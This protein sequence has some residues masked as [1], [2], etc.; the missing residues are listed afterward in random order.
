MGAPTR[1]TNGVT[2]VSKAAPM[3]A[4]PLP[5]PIHSS[6]SAG[7]QVFS[8]INDFTEMGTTTANTLVNST[9]AGVSEVGGVAL[10]T[11]ATAAVASVVRTAANF[12]FVT[13]SDF[14]YVTRHKQSAITA[15][16]TQRVGLQN[17]LLA[18]TTQESIYFTSTAGGALSLVSNVAGVA[19]TLVASVLPSIAAATYVDVG[20]YFDGNDLSVFAND[21]LVAKVTSPSL[22]TLILSPF[23]QITPTAALE[24]LSQDYVIVAQETVR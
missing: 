18:N 6:V 12:Q 1:F 15:A 17:G 19:T 16:V 9:Y 7:K 11:P 8:Y 4:Y 10:L 23:A 2:T 20:F 3:G 14:W 5:D 13:G 24:T 22:P 21:S